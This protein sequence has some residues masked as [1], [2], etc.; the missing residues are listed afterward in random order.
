M[1]KTWFCALVLTALSAI[2]AVRIGVN[3]TEFQDELGPKLKDL[4]KSGL[5]TIEQFDLA[6]TL[7]ESV[8][9]LLKTLWKCKQLPDTKASEDGQ[10][11]VKCPLVQ[12]REAVEVILSS[13]QLVA[14]GSMSL[15]EFEN[16]VSTCKITTC[17]HSELI[18][19]SKLTDFLKQDD[20][21]AEDENF[22]KCFR[23]E[24]IHQKLVL[25]GRTADRNS[26]I[27][28]CTCSD[29]RPLVTE[30]DL[31]KVVI[32]KKIIRSPVMMREAAGEYCELLGLKD[33]TTYIA[34]FQ[35]ACKNKQ[36]GYCCSSGFED[37][38]IA[39]KEKKLTATL[40][41]VLEISKIVQAVIDGSNDVFTKV[42]AVMTSEIADRQQKVMLYKMYVIHF[43][44]AQIFLKRHQ[45][46]TKHPE[47]L[48]V[49]SDPM[50]LVAILNKVWK[51]LEQTESSIRLLADCIADGIR[52]VSEEIAQGTGFV[53][54]LYNVLYR[55][56]RFLGTGQLVAKV[57]QLAMILGET[58]WK[59]RFEI[60]ITGVVVSGSAPLMAALTATGITTGTA[61]SW[62]LVFEQFLRNVMVHIACP[63][64]KS[65]LLMSM[66]IRWTMAKV[67]L[68]DFFI[69]NAIKPFWMI[70]QAANP[71]WYYSQVQ[72]MLHRIRE[73]LLGTNAS[74]TMMQQKTW[75]DAAREFHNKPAAD[76]LYGVLS[77]WLGSIW[78]VATSGICAVL[79]LGTTVMSGVE[80][81]AD[82]AS[83]AVEHW[84]TDMARWVSSGVKTIIGQGG[85]AQIINDMAADDR[86]AR[87]AMGRIAPKVLATAHMALSKINTLGIATAEMSLDA[88]MN[89]METV[90]TS[91]GVTYALSGLFSY[92]FK[93]WFMA[94]GLQPVDDRVL[95]A[96]QETERLNFNEESCQGQALWSQC[97]LLKDPSLVTEEV[98]SGV[99][100]NSQCQPKEDLCPSLTSEEL[101]DIDEFDPRTV[102]LSHLAMQSKYLN[103]FVETAQDANPQCSADELGWV[104][105]ITGWFR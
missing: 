103:R 59:Y 91:G 40:S 72:K 78:R 80:S 98:I 68:S 6:T 35:A 70:V 99:C 37:R 39:V 36:Q 66:L 46:C 17:K 58:I 20:S 89:T 104:D 88:I 13:G 28:E 5:L 82:A 25:S 19:L 81:T 16:E 50:I 22:E 27:G 65:P 97:L 63:V 8:P 49:C 10:S 74:Q 95:F 64:L 77:I 94:K 52:P 48:S 57:N 24:Q 3:S 7:R 44:H 73:A 71:T 15:E 83:S 60:V 61:T 11:T 102:P 4:K 23:S 85:S 2:D 47:D 62:S 101:E 87:E 42:S 30:A 96:F 67:I 53:S 92:F 51:S 86:F 84:W 32:Q 14:D 33:E 1:Y 75:L 29:K 31:R 76:F 93:G 21:C 45:Y 105:K 43:H 90:A 18:H 34:T 9:T 100:C 12:R 26:Q 56:V 55:S 54:L 41:S 79:T 69:E 38:A